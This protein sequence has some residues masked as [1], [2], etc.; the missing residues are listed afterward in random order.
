MTQ[1]PIKL[2]VLLTC[3]NRR[4]KT[5]RCLESLDL[6][7]NT[8]GGI[9]TLVWLVDD[10]STDGT[11]EAV[12]ERFP[13]VRLISGDGRLFWCGGMRM[14][15]QHAAQ[16]QADAYLWLNDDV[17]LDAG[18][19]QRMAETARDNPEAIVIGS[20]RC[21]ETGKHTYGGQRRSG[22]HPGRVVAAP[23]TDRIQECDTFQGNLVWIPAKVFA[24]VGNMVGYSHAMAD[25]DYGYEAVKRGFRILIAPGYF[26]T[27]PRNP[28]DSA[29]RDRSLPL[30]ARFKKINSFKGLPPR[31]W[32]RFCFRHGGLMAPAYFAAPYIRALLNR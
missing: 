9:D 19:V 4:E 21:P 15:W 24:T 11:A 17:T 32:F 28:G 7:G 6:G 2:A 20:C 8:V 18:T 26:G 5:L 14:A 13:E 22:R 10:G 29:W 27:C 30:A 25:T 16:E 31:D 3:H 12:K 1:N 23:P